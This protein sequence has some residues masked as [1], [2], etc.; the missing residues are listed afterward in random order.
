MTLSGT[1]W[2]HS[3]PPCKDNL[4]A[5]AVGIIIPVRNGLKF[6]KLCF[7]SVLSFTDHPYTLAIV[8]NLSDLS[9]KKYFRAISKNHP[10]NVLRYD[11]EF[12]FAAE[13]N[14]GCK[15]VFSFPSVK[16]ALILNADTVVS[17]NYLSQMIKAINL[18]E[19]IG[20]VGPMSNR[21]IPEQAELHRY[22]SY[23]V[24][25]RVSGFCMLIRRET[26]EE[27]GGFDEGFAGGGFEDWDICERARRKG[28]HV[29][30][31]GFTYIHHFWRAFR[32]GNHHASMEA[33]EKRFFEKHPTLR[34]LVDRVGAA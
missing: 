19:R 24:A 23:T 13:M 10:I 21:S 34:V 16:Y 1:D 33:N 7:H 31:D 14:V 18:Q 4:P 28:W 25:Q 32:Q 3:T 15:Y 2:P 27:V 9:T 17:P 29:Y 11:E 5:N 20:I 26:F 22:N 30:V 6:F 8:D 12:N